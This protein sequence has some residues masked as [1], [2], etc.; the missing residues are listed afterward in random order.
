MKQTA[1]IAQLRKIA[2]APVLLHTIH[3]TPLIDH[4]VRSRAKLLGV[5][6]AEFYRTV[7]QAVMMEWIKN[8]LYQIPEE[9]FSPSEAPVRNAPPSARIAKRYLDPE[10]PRMA[11][12]IND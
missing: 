1:R 11:N 4:F 12:S 10:P 9:L 2:S 3:V 5:S 8:G 6:Q 7:V